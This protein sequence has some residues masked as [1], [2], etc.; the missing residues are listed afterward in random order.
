M[1]HLIYVP[2]RG[3]IIN[4]FWCELQ[5]L[6]MIYAKNI[7]L[8]HFVASFVS[9]CFAFKRDRNQMNDFIFHLV[10]FFLRKRKNIKYEVKI[11]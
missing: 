9:F 4:Y 1:H 8:L 10:F 5:K 7:S 6:K 3:L 11:N 2:Y